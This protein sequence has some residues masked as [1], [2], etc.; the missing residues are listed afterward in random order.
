MDSVVPSLQ[1][2]VSFRLKRING[3]WSLV[4]DFYFES[5][6]VA[7]LSEPFF[8]SFKMALHKFYGSSTSATVQNYLPM[9]KLS[10]MAESANTDK[11]ISNSK[12]PTKDTF[13][14]IQLSLYYKVQFS[15]GETFL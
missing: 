7:I 4:Y 14:A 3:Q 13:Q 12:D 9:G 11:P 1:R 5:S 8:V 2:A 15:R 6:K 10:T